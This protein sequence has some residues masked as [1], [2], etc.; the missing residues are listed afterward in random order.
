MMTRCP[1]DRQLALAAASLFLCMASALPAFA[2]TAREAQAR[3][4]QDMASCNNGQS[5]QDPA[6]CRLEARN[7]L[8]DAR[9][10]DLH[11]AP[12]KYTNNARQR[13]NALEGDNRSDCESRLRGEGLSEGSVGG[14]G[15][16]RETVT[17]VPGE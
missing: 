5:P 14:G 17:V 6:T 8:T 9:R 15:I 1:L 3:F 16:I 10:G 12:E 2:D 13:C 11:G 4:R 7:A